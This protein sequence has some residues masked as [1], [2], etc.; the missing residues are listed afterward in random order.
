MAPAACRAARSRSLLAW[1]F[2]LRRSPRMMCCCKTTLTRFNVSLKSGFETVPP[3][4]MPAS[5]AV[6]VRSSRD[7]KRMEPLSP[8]FGLN[9][10]CVKL[11]G[12]GTLT[13]REKLCR[14]MAK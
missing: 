5:R 2:L 12:P 7:L 3:V 14:T 4:E 11:S 9:K 8:K 10:L 6:R 13:T 1:Y